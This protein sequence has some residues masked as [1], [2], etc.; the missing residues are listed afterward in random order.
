VVDAAC[1]TLN[2]FRRLI[3]CGGTFTVSG[4]PLRTSCTPMKSVTLLDPPR[5]VEFT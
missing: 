3:R 2:P 1:D 5:L 4:E